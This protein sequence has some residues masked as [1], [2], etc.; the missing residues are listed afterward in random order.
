MYIYHGFYLYNC[1]SDIYILFS[2]YIY[3]CFIWMIVKHYITQQYRW[4]P[5]GSSALASC[6]KWKTIRGCTDFI[7]RFW[8]METCSVTYT[9]ILVYPEKQGDSRRCAKH[10]TWRY[11]PLGQW[12]VVYNY[13]SQRNN[14]YFEVYF[15]TYIL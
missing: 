9:W 2:V 10:I 12:A 13:H 6:I 15:A 14:I 8:G 7:L 4:K 5:V 11:C 3:H 1:Y